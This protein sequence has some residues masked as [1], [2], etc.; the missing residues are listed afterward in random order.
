MNLLLTGRRIKGEEALAIGLCD[1]LVAA[2]VL[3]VEAHAV[4][5]QIAACSPRAIRSIRQ[6]MRA[7]L[8]DR[9]RAATEHEAI[10]QEWLQ[11][12]PDWAEGVRAAAEG[13]PPSFGA[14]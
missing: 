7:G 14:Q 4:A 5:A 11:S 12:N 10:E 1:S 9:V 8:L 6:T 3:R 2:D 13:R